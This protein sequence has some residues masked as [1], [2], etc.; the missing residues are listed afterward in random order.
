MSQYLKPTNIFNRYLNL[1]NYFAIYRIF[2][3]FTDPLNFIVKVITKKVPNK[4]YV[5]TPIGTIQLYPRNIESLYTIY[6]VFCRGDY[7]IDHNKTSVILDIGANCGYTASYFLSRNKKN[8]VICYEPDP[9][10]VKFLNTNLSKFNDRF[11][12]IDS[13]VGVSNS[14]SKLYLSEC[15]KYNTIIRSKNSKIIKIN[16]ISINDILDLHSEKKNLIIKI[17]IEGIEKELLKKID[18]NKYP[19]IKKIMVESIGCSDLIEIDHKLKV[20]NSYVEHISFE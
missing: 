17:D 19:Y 20:V 1:Y 10:N 7:K 3:V 5:R 14:E 2:F 12:I 9:K 4:L 13:G 8:Q 11:Q 18:F 15:G 16:L 6:S